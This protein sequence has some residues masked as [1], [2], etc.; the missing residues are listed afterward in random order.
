MYEEFVVM[1]F[2]CGLNL[3]YSYLGNQNT[4]SGIVIQP[5]WLW[6]WQFCLGPCN[7]TT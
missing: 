2:V 6:L 7:K 1:T 5:C 3:P 4:R